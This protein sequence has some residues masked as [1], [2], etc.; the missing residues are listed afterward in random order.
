MVL[1]VAHHDE[2]YVKVTGEKSYEQELS[3]YFTFK[4]PGYKFMPAYRNKMWDGNIRL[5]NR[6]SHT[7]YAGLIPYI[8]Q[9]CEDREYDVDVDPILEQTDEFSIK[10]AKDFIKELSPTMEPRDYQLDAFVKCVR[11]KRRLVLSPTAS[12]KSFIIYLLTRWYESKTLVIVPTISLVNQM[13][14]DFEDY[15][16]KEQIH[17]I[18]AGAEKYT[19]NNITVS[20]WQSIHRM[21]KQYFDQF[22][23]V[24]GDEAHLYKAK[25]LTS[26]L[27]KLTDCK[28]RFGFTGTLDGTHTHKLVLEGLF[29]SVYNNITTKELIDKE[30]LAQFKIKA[31]ILKYTEATRK[32]LRQATYRDEIDFL[33]ACPERNNFIQQL[34]L[35]LEGNTLLLFTQV[36]KHGKL[37]FDLIENKA[38]KER[39]IFFV[40]GGTDADTRESVRAITEKEENAIIVAS[41]GTFSTGINIKRLHNIVFTSPTKSRIRALQSIG[42]GLRKGGGDEEA[43]IEGKEQATLFD[44]ADDL[45][46]KARVN[47]TLKHFIER[48]KYYTS[49]KFE[50]KVYNINFKG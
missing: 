43:G 16:Y 34:A 20:T 2:V 3:D 31:L 9:F 32:M 29:G 50:Y 25:S 13:A 1:K 36:E 38:E 49:E 15:G 33:M 26:I 19:E 14:K 30:H 4:V 41:Y 6:R 28:Y 8:K 40:Y 5:F 39:K 27:E 7:L 12:G 35:S 22:D 24:I 23:V 10:D 37:L 46:W 17:R 45:T 18:S 42:R 44:I 21:P 48:M 47:Y 11:S